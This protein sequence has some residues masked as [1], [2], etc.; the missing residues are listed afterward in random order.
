MEQAAEAR[1]QSVSDPEVMRALAH[2][3]RMAILEHLT[4]TGGAITATEA[5]K[6]V[7]LSPS[8]T[9]YHLRALAKAGL[10]EDA[11]GRGDG[12]ERVWRTPYRG[13][14]FSA[15]PDASPDAIA[16]ERALVDMFMKRER[17]RLEDWFERSREQP[18]EWFEAAFL[19]ESVLL[20]TAAELT[21]VLAKVTEI[22]APYKRA[23]RPSPPP[24]ARRVS[25]QMRGVPIDYAV[26]EET[27]KP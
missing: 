13:W 4:T 17:E 26:D 8:A 9:S 19:S 21:E 24:G 3:A 27:M 12:R 22:I 11:P 6:L 25:F 10:V 14:T 20:L 1:R 16:A 15:G 18:L 23:G 5:A 2:P 7:G